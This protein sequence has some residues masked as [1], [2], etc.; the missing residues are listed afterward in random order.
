[1]FLSFFFLL[2]KKFLCKNKKKFKKQQQKLKRKKIKSLHLGFNVTPLTNIDTIK[3]LS[4]I[5]VLHSS[6]LRDL[7]TGKRHL[8]DIN[9]RDFDL[10]LDISSSVVVDTIEKLD[11]SDLLLTQKVSDFNKGLAVVLNTGNIDGKVGIAESHLVFESLS[12]T[13]DHVLDV[14]AN[15]SDGSNGLPVT[16]PQVNF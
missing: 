10:I 2:Q 4:D 1:L 13:G 9:A 16:K 8:G 7:S 6:R 15:G 14:G 11:S 12:D 5:L 3:E